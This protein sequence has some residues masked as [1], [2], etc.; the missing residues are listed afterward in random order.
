MLS[1][2]GARS[3]KESAS[4]RPLPH[5]R[6]AMIPFHYQQRSARPRHLT[7]HVDRDPLGQILFAQDY[8][9]NVFSGIE[10]RIMLAQVQ[11]LDYQI[12]WMLRSK[13]LKGETLL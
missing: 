13:W 6:D 8:V 1:P 11:L 4:Q 5:C 12:R 10:R 9:G 3:S 2:F 7:S